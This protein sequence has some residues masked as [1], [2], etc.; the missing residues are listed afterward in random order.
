LEDNPIINLHSENPKL[1]D[2][3]PALHRIRKQRLKLHIM[4][5]F[6]Q[7]CPQKEKLMKLFQG[8][9]HLMETTELY[10]MIDL[11]EVHNGTMEK[12]LKKLLHRLDIYTSSAN[13]RHPDMPL[14]NTHNQSMQVGD[15]HHTTVQ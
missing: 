3:V 10:S 13:A 9:S 1:F 2:K 4:D 8:K 11:A 14:E 15:A 6:I 7:N 5:Q 12:F